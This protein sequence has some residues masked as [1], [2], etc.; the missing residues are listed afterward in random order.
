MQMLDISC[1]DFSVRYNNL[2]DFMLHIL[3]WYESACYYEEY[4]V[5]E[6]KAEIEWELQ[7]KYMTQEYILEFINDSRTYPTQKNN[8]QKYVEEF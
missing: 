7:A 6:V 4:G 8:L 1:N 2:T 3:A 5:W